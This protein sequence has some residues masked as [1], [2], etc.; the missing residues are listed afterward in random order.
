MIRKMEDRVRDAALMPGAH[1]PTVEEDRH[2]QATFQGEEL[3]QRAWQVPD[4]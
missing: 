1:V 2:P 3:W 4:G